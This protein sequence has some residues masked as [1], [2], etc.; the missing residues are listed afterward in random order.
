MRKPKG[1]K[2]YKKLDFVFLLSNTHIS[3]P[4]L[5]F[6]VTWYERS[7]QGERKIVIGSK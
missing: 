3:Q 2:R 1:K 4:L 6:R 7:M 5:N